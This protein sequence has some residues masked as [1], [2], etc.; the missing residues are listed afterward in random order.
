MYSN[1]D[2]KDIE[3]IHNLPDTFHEHLL[4]KFKEFNIE[5][6]NALEKVELETSNKKNTYIN[7]IKVLFEKL[8]NLVNLTNS[9]KN[10]KF[11]S[12]CVI[13]GQRPGYY[14][15]KPTVE[16]WK[17]TNLIETL[18]IESF[19]KI[20]E[21]KG[22][23]CQLYMNDVKYEL[24]YDDVMGGTWLYTGGHN[25]TVTWNPKSLC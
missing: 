6:K 7:H 21:N 9:N 10:D 8:I 17:T 23:D 22:Y 14:Y 18:V 25:I 3:A 13:T 16:S 20:M 24:S 5:R 15:N 2:V 1:L 19:I 11:P 4:D 12:Q